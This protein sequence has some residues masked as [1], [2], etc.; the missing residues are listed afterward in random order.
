MQLKSSA[1]SLLRAPENGY[2]IGAFGA[3]NMEMVQA[4]VEAAEELSSPVFIQTTPAT[5][6]HADVAIYS[7][8][9]NAAAKNSSVPVAMHLDHGKTLALCKKAIEAQYTSVMMDGSALPFEENISLSREV[10]AIAKSKGIPVEVELGTIGGKEDDHQVSDNKA[11]YTDPNQA[12][13]F[14]DRSGVQS[15]AVA[16]GTAHGFYQQQ[17][18][19]D[20][21][22]LGGKK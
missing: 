18:R 11:L 16:I 1:E 9:V 3:E 7:A 8:M 19:L 21:D 20:F 15:L 6:A 17:P 22:R 12:K 4:I 10:V 13:E 14:I 5:I 2:A